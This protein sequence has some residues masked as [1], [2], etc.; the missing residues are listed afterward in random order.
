MNIERIGPDF[1]VTKIAPF[2]HLHTL[3]TAPW[4]AASSIEII[5][6]NEIPNEAF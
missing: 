4:T 6:V 2:Q 1:N 5:L 3:K